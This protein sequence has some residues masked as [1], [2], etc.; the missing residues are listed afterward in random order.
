M[1]FGLLFFFIRGLKNIFVWYLTLISLSF[2][3]LVFIIKY[4]I[5]TMCAIS[6]A[7]IYFCFSLAFDF[8]IYIIK[9][10]ILRLRAFIFGRFI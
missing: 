6:I 10:F 2:N 8:F 5:I 3:G 7:V 9:S 1:T 4:T